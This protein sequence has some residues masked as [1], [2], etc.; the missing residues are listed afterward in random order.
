[1]RLLPFTF[2]SKFSQ[3]TIVTLFVLTSSL[4]FGQKNYYKPTPIQYT[5]GQIMANFASNG[6]NPVM[7]FSDPE[8]L[9]PNHV[10]LN[11]KAFIR[12]NADSETGSF[13]WT[14]TILEVTVIPIL[15]DNSEDLSSQ[16]SLTLEVEYNPAG[17]SSNFVDLANHDLL[18]A[19]G[20]KVVVNSISSI[21]MLG[22]I[23]PSD[24]VNP[25]ISLEL[26]FEAERYY[27]LTTQNIDIQSVIQSDSDGPVALQFNWQPLVGA[28]EYELEW[29]WVDNYNSND[30]NAVLPANQINFSNRDFELNNTRIK[31]SKTSYEIPLIY[32]KGYIIYRIRPVSRFIDDITKVF[33]GQWN[34]GNTPKTKVS[35]WENSYIQIV[36]HE[37][38]KNW[39]FQ[40]SYAEDG[41]KKEVV[42]YFDGSL[43]NRQTVTKVNS[44]NNT[45]VG[46]VIYDA[47]GRP[48]IEV[49]PTPI[50]KNYIRYYKGLN[51]NLNNKLYTH[52]DF[53]WSD[54]T[55]AACNTF[56]GQMSDI[57]G[58]SQYYSDS[59]NV[60]SAFRNFIPN[61][62]KFPF[63]QI[64][65]TPDNT[66][67][68]A[69]KGGV[70]FEH[71]LGRGHEMKYF[72]TVP[73]QEEL[74]RLFGYSVGFASHYK[75]NIVVDP[76]GQVSVSY[77]DPQGRTIATALAGENP[78]A[79]VSLE[80]GQS[81]TLH[82]DFTI[83]L[84]GKVGVEDT[85][86]ALD[87]NELSTTYN[88][89]IYEDLLSLSQ[90]VGVAGNGV[91][92]EFEYKIK[93]N[94]FFQP[95]FCEDKYSFVYDLSISLKDQCAQDQIIPVVT[96]I[97]NVSYT[98]AILDSQN[99]PITATIP[100]DPL[101]P[102]KVSMDEG[103]ELS[104]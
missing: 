5:N 72:Y 57:N 43:R 19:Y 59:N 51:L 71:Q 81:S 24:V 104:S 38:I 89:S 88:F 49:L 18:N 9:V 23:P 10:S 37:N 27:Q 93:N 53:D 56:I 87:K 8:Y 22:V 82:Q 99:I 11:P 3:L 42:S 36:E 85:D 55:A 21:D 62:N 73:F 80:D 60:T 74:N 34:C 90:S 45:I 97:G 66:G 52:L 64:E 67:R 84:L 48:A 40:A 6:S 35:D 25:N 92:Y 44:E 78:S 58:S 61:A 12:L 14:K 7:V 63:S 28:L 65:Y 103:F 39:Q 20:V 16:Y 70:G 91:K 95:E 1:M 86:T 68:I 96:Q 79:L 17:N 69:R 47:Q 100:V 54:T 26:G 30:V 29:T 2:I 75:K 31:T 41:K 94:N 83:D 15:S 77:I 32:S 50:N 46:E 4:I 102:E 33:Y 98:G 101:A 76:N 13:S